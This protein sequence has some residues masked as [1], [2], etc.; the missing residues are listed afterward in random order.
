[1]PFLNSSGIH[2]ETTFQPYIAKGRIFNGYT[3][4]FWIADEVGKQWYG[5][6]N[7]VMY[8]R[9][10]WE[11]HVKPGSCVLDCGSHHGM[12][13]ILLSH[14]CTP[15]GHVIAVDALPANVAVIEQN[16]ELNSLTNI[17]VHAAALWNQLGFLSFHEQSGNVVCIGMAEESGQRLLKADTIDNIAAGRRIDFLKLDVE[18]SDLQALQ[19]AKCT[20]L[21]RPTLAIEFH[22]FTFKDRRATVSE[23]LSLLG[24]AYKY[25]F[26]GEGTDQVSPDVDRDKLLDLIC[27]FDNPHLYGLPASA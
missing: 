18:G 2:Q 11:Q 23:I 14:F 12:A 27:S 21:Q 8:E 13:A 16:V 15:T 10:W 25:E 5:F 24:P 3:F 6:S 7:Q 4:D 26:Q 17:E 9:L 1:M 20:L 19:G 22:C